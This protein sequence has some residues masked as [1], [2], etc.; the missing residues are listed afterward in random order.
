MSRVSVIFPRAC[1]KSA[2]ELQQA[3]DRKLKGRITK[4]IFS[5]GLS[6]VDYMGVPRVNHATAIR[7]CIN[8][9]KTLSTFKRFKIPTV[10][11][12]T[13][14]RDIP[15]HWDVI[16]VREKV[17]GKGNEGLHFVEAPLPNVFKHKPLYTNYFEH[18]ME[19]RVV[20]FMGKVFTYR[21]HQVLDE[22]EFYPFRAPKSLTEDAIRAAK[23]LG[24]DY[25]GFD[26]LY[27]N[28]G[29]YAFLEANSGPV[30]IEDV[31]DYIVDWFVNKLKG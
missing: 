31:R 8:K 4:Y 17:D 27:N 26:V 16:V 19:L 12:C 9:V 25:V 23:G 29:S 21:K 10:E 2:E 13:N 22:W 1:Q 18:R 6:E 7:R 20:V 24:I 5:Y 11:Y 3:L 30:L 15:R 14:H 28:K